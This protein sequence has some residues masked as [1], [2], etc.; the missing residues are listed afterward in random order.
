MD[1]DFED[2]S[3]LNKLHVLQSARRNQLQAEVLQVNLLGDV[4]RD[5]MEISNE[6]SPFL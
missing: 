2:D 3:Y 4:Q 1:S 6:L 5:L